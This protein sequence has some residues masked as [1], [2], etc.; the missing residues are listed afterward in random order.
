MRGGVH[1]RQGAGPHEAELDGRE[2]MGP[3]VGV[4]QGMELGNR[5]LPMGASADGAE[6]SEQGWS[7]PSL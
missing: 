7:A 5:A 4:G 3:D 6:G 1:V 2:L